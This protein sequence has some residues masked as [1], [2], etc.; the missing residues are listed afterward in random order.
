VGLCIPTLNPANWIDPMIT[1]LKAQRHT[2]DRVVVIDSSSEDG[3]VSRFKE[4]EAEIVT[5]PRHQF[6]HGGTRNLGAR[7]LETDIVVFLTQDAIPANDEAIGN[8]V[9]AVWANPRRAVA[10]GRQ[11]PAKRAGPLASAHRAFNYGPDP[12]E[13]T[14]ADISRLGVRAA[15]NSNSFAAYRSEAL[16][17]VG[18]FPN[19]VV[20]SEDRWIAA[21]FL[22]AGWAV[23]YAPE[24]AVVHSHDY[25]YRQD[26]R[27]YFDIGV[28]HSTEAWFD[29]VLGPPQ[30][31]GIRLVRAQLRTLRAAGARWSGATVVT[32]AAASWLGFQVG[33]RHARLPR[34]LVA[35]WS[36]APAYFEVEVSARPRSA[37]EKPSC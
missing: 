30:D 8:L 15:F 20:G 34:G 2:L 6:D 7:L 22:Q 16:H 19:R 28:F 33:R 25:T 10:F 9:A 29:E 12:F 23:A 26:F 32:H 5:I 4:V 14:S 31:E 35:R 3:A 37:R 21:R 11:L 27:R 17:S 13:R 1:A 18:G 24:A 36:T